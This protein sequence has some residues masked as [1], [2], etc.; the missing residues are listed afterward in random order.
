M[1]NK[2]EKQIVICKIIASIFVILMSIY[3]IIM[4]H[5]LINNETYGNIF[6]LWLDFSISMSL[7]K[8]L[9]TKNEKKIIEQLSKIGITY[10]FIWL[11]IAIFR[12]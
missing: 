12:M 7:I 5:L 1:K 3:V 8:A 11:Y 9:W 10:G 6:K 2:Y 4:I